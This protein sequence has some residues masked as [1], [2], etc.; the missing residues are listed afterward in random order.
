MG[1]DIRRLPGGI[2]DN[3]FE[4]GGHSL[5]AVQLMAKLQPV[6]QQQL[7]LRTLFASPTVAMLAAHVQQSTSSNAR[8]TEPTT[9]VTLQS[10]GSEPSFVCLPGAGG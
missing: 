8:A 10:H 4:I 7:P 2:H 5:L 9:L 1:T 6:I 3:F